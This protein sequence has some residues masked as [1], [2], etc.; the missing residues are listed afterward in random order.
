[1]D[2][3]LDTPI[4]RDACYQI[5]HDQ[6]FP[7]CRAEGDLVG[8]EIEAIT[9]QIT[10]AS[11]PA[12]VPFFNPKGKGL[13]TVLRDLAQQ[14]G[15]SDAYEGDEL[16]SKEAL[17]LN[18]GDSGDSLTFEPGGQIEYSSAPHRDVSTVL[19]RS[20]EV[21]EQLAAH[22][23][24]HSIQL[25]RIG[26]NPWHTVAEIGLQI[27]K[28]AYL[29]LDH[30]FGNFSPIG[31]RMMQQT[32]TQQLNLDCGAHDELVAKRYLVCNLLAPYGAAMFANSGVW[33][34]QHMGLRGFRT[35]IWR[36]LDR[37][38]TGF[39]D[40]RGVA[41][42]R[43]R[44]ACAQAYVDFAL[45]ALI[46]HLSNSPSRGITFQ[47]W[48]D[49]GIE[50][51]RPTV[52]D[53]QDHLYTLFPEVRPRGY[54]ELRSLDCQLL[55]W[56]HAPVA[57]YLGIV[58]HPTHLDR[59]L[60]ELL[61]ELGQQEKMMHLACHGLAQ[62]DENFHQRLC[63]LAELA[64]T[65]MGTLPPRLRC[66]DAQKRLQFFFEHFTLQSKTPAADMQLLAK[67]SDADYLCPA[68]LS[69]LEATWVARLA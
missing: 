36:E 57:F 63:W 45:Q 21:Q 12:V 69:R 6:L 34:R 23:A 67:N 18:W 9:A 19:R 27:P 55:G 39:P 64:I 38:R 65:G 43:S 13:R 49:A 48:L 47:D 10:P 28:T 22:L 51:K 59:A 14:E 4:D 25:L 2:T 20:Q 50:G 42:E 3:P 62:R 46:V 53:F 7:L 16:L 24:Q 54:L 17:K 5:V 56:Q 44:A 29:L 26:I 11:L 35:H 1:M 66:A 15:W 31:R 40:L 61:P 52:R 41:R 8:I 60:D 37:S 33:D 58:Y 32:C 68:Q 30:H